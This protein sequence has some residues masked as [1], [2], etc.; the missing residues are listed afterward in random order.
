MTLVLIGTS[1]VSGA[2]NGIVSLS[3]YQFAYGLF[4]L[5]MTCLI[6]D[7]VLTSFM[8]YYFQVF[9]RRVVS[10]R[11][12]WTLVIFAGIPFFLFQ[13]IASL[14]PPI[15]LIGL[16]FSGFLLAVG[17]SEN[18][19]LEK[20]RALRLIAL[21]YL[22]VFSVWLWDKIR[23]SSHDRRMSLPADVN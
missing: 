9:E 16:A 10:F 11:K 14:I 8:Y 5:P 6:T 7:F 15:T 20:K 19:K 12:L 18:F 21:L 1:L 22:M 13:A 17:L 4:V 2:L 3:F 23:F